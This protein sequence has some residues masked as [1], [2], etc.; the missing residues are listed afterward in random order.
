M[1]REIFKCL[2]SFDDH[3][4]IFMCDAFE[5]EGAF[6]LV[7]KWLHYR[8]EKQATPKRVIRVEN[9]SVRPLGAGH[10]ARYLIPEPL[11]AILRDAVTAEEIPPGYEVR[12][13]LQEK[14]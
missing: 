6:W 5:R 9:A 14:E 12:F 10:P 11:P 4:A 13:A 3:G 8:D 2:V 1:N 7:P